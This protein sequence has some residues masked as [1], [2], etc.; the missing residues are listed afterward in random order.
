MTSR[1]TDR[2]GEAARRV[3]WSEHP[4][5]DAF[6]M[7]CGVDDVPLKKFIAFVREMPNRQF[8]AC[9]RRGITLSYG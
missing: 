6:R 7:S 1:D 9:M 5:I 3:F 4:L 8:D 2:R